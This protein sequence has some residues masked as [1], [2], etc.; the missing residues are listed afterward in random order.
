MLIRIN[1]IHNVIFNF[2]NTEGNLQ[3]GHVVF[4]MDILLHMCIIFQT[5]HK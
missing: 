2:Y 3:Y 5:S 1:M 4:D